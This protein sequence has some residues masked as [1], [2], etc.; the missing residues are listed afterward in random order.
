M[1]RVRELNGLKDPTLFREASYVAG[2]WRASSTGE[3][4]AVSPYSGETL[5]QIDI[6]RGTFIA[7]IV[8]NKTVFVL[9]D[10]ADLLALR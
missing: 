9:T 4:L 2:E 3:M 5:G 7:P 1:E 6:P 10:G 8:A